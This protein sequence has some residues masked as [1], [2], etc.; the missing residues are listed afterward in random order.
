[1]EAAG[2][3][4]A[5]RS[6]VSMHLALVISARNKPECGTVSVCLVCLPEIHISRNRNRESTLL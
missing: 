6:D 1:M 4:R 3:V 5:V 2:S